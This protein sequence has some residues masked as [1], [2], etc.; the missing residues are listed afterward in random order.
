MRARALAPHTARALRAALRVHSSL[1]ACTRTGHTSDQPS[2]SPP[3]SPTGPDMQGLALHSRSGQPC[4][5]TP[6]GGRYACTRTGHTSDQPS[7][8]PPLSHPPGLICTRSHFTHDLGRLACTLPPGAATHARAPHTLHQLSLSLSHSPGL[9]RTRSHHTRAPGRLACT[10]PAG[11]ASHAL[12]PA[13]RRT[14]FLCLSL[15]PSPAG[16]NARAC[17]TRALGAT[18]RVH[19]RQ[20]PLHMHEHR[21]IVGT[22]LFVSLSHPPRLKCTRSHRT[23]A[24]SRL[25]CTL[26]PGFFT[27][28]GQL[29]ATVRLACTLPQGAA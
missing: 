9:V 23:R 20:G 25:A 29:L 28:T 15:S 2:L 13:K 4:V 11:A 26:P 16:P 10:L 27:Q 12:A 18:L 3:L 6:A 1:L 14:S 22:A 19:A 24:P 8:S 5:Y 7:L 21:L 17:T